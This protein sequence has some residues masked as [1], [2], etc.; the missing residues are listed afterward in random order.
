MPI[1]WDWNY[2]MNNE[3]IK[4]YIMEIIKNK[5]FEANVLYSLHTTCNWKM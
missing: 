2:K 3:T 1:E 5:E 4:Y